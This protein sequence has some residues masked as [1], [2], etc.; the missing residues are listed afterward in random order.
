MK[1]VNKTLEKIKIK[2]VPMTEDEV[3]EIAGKILGLE[4]TDTSISGV[5]QIT[6]FNQLGF[7][8]VKD[9]PDGWY[10]PNEVSF[11][12]II[13]E[14]KSEST[15]IKKAHI[16][17]L[18]KN[19]TIIE[20]KYKKH[21]GILY[22]GFVVKI[23]K[24]GIFLRE[25]KELKNKEYYLSL[26]SE[27]KID[28][29]KIYNITAKINNNLHFNF[30]IKNLYHRMIFTACAL[31]AKRY[32]SV[33]IKGMNYTTFHTSIHTTLAKSFEEARRQNVKLDIL[34]EAYSSI[35]MNITENQTAIDNFIESVCEISDNINSDFWNGEDVMAIFFNEFNRYKGKS[36]SGQV[37]TPD[38]ITSLMYKITEVNKDDLV[39][40]AACG[41]GAFLVKAMCN[42]IK[43]AGGNSTDKAKIIKEEQLFG[44]ELDKEIYALACANML[45]HKDGKT[46][47]EQFDA[48]S[49]EAK[50][51]IKSK[52]ITKILMNPPFEN[53]Y[54]CLDI[55]LNVL[56]SLE[57][58]KTCAFIMPDNK[59]ETNIKKAKKILNN[60]YL[61]KIIK[62][63]NEIFSGVTSSIFI[64]KSGIPQDDKKIF[65]CAILDDGLETIKNQ[66]R[67]DIKNKWEEIE[68]Y[69][70][71]VIY[72]QSGDS[73][74]QWLNPNENL[75]YKALEKPFEISE[76]DFKKT[77]LNY[78]LFKSNINPDEFKTRIID[79][80]LYNNRNNIN[81]ELIEII[82]SKISLDNDNLDINATEWKKFSI[83]GENGIFKLMH[84][85]PRKSTEY[86]EE[87]EIPFVA[88]GA[89]N[90][91][92]EKYVKTDEILDK[93]KCIT[94]SAIGGFAFYQ[95]KD[96]I[97]RG[98]AGSAIKILYSDRLNE[99]NALFI[100]TV[101]QKSLSK[102]NFTIMLSG[103]K[104]KKEYIYLPTLGNNE[105]DWEYM[106]KYIDSIYELSN[107]WIQKT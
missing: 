20:K 32:G 60:H 105:I 43:E 96:F 70:V 95:D 89:F 7:S 35:K 27:N 97:G 26:F 24:D 16:D 103:D 102:Y 91:G 23:Y 92:I 87:G 76:H 28:T 100:C 21:I 53:K 17:E 64:F 4:N 48:R 80:V 75:S 6:S 66:G 33:L 93:G 81:N 58:D 83:C 90:N 47:L 22:N 65:A 34:L 78:I 71:D 106:E 56:E 72:R 1:E 57:K 74:I 5:G 101:L 98:G 14:A 59:L 104:L 39:L 50:K 11:P 69:W 63:P 31:V 107:L 18:L 84:P 99:K 40:D 42:M 41:S 94:V 46:N 49:Y 88:S 3:R 85:K 55:V 38:H 44:I 61:T 73:S 10:L 30:G 29:Q 19:L 77:V 8:G 12:A 82:K 79:F 9:R 13:L 62:L 67:Q 86:L 2:N 37:F 52:K 51:W 68:R 36:E 45:I 54:G 15:T 25:E